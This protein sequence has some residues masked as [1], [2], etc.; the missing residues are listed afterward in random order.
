MSTKIESG[1]ATPM[2]YESW[3]SARRASL[4]WTKDLAIQRARYAADRST[5]EK[6]LPEKAPPP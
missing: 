4:A 6:S 5:L 1:S 2:A 3:T